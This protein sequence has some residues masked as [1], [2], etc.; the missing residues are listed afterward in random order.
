M[1]K[2]RGGAGRLDVG[3]LKGPGPAMDD[4][5]MNSIP[6]AGPCGLPCGGKCWKNAPIEV[7]GGGVGSR[8]WVMGGGDEPSSAEEASELIGSSFC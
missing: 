8:S 3:I 1:D 6:P 4:G 7:G 5:G 2:L